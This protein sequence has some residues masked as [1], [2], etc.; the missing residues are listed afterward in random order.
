MTFRPRRRKAACPQTT[1]A[2]TEPRVRSR[3]GFPVLTSAASPWVSGRAL[4]PGPSAAVFFLVVVDPSRQTATASMSGSS[5]REPRP[6]RRYRGIRTRHGDLREHRT[7][8][9]DLELLVRDVADRLKLAAAGQFDDR[10]VSKGEKTAFFTVA[11][12]V[13]PARCPC[14]PGRPA[15]FADGGDNRARP[16]LSSKV[17]RSRRPSVD[18]ECLVSCSSVTQK[19]SPM[20]KTFPGPDTHAAIVPCS[21]GRGSRTRKPGREEDDP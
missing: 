1:H 18:Q 12:T 16:V 8:G 20:E 3:Q 10:P 21:C 13:P 14:C 7:A 11:M 6:R 19:S 15:S 2:R 4:F 5:W 9:T 17:C